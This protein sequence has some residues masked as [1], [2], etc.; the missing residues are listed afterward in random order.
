MLME[1]LC[2]FKTITTV[3]RRHDAREYTET[4]FGYCEGDK[5]MMYKFCKDDEPD[6]KETKN[7][8]KQFVPWEAN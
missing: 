4:K 6:F 3:V 2:P 5:C 8:E 1:K 7:G